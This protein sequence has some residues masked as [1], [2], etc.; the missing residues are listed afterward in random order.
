MPLGHYVDKNTAVHR[1]KPTTKI[2][3]IMVA[4]VVIT[5]MSRTIGI[6]FNAFGLVVL[7]VEVLVTMSV[8][9]LA[10]IP[11][12]VAASQLLP[13]VPVLAFITIFQ[14]WSVGW[15]SALSLAT[16]L[17]VS[18]AL[19]LILTL[20]TRIGDMIESLDLAL[21]PLARFH[22]PVNAISVAIAI[23]IRLIPLQMENIRVVIE[24]RRARSSRGLRAFALPVII[25]SIRRAEAMGEALE[26]RGFDD[27][28]PT[29]SEYVS[30]E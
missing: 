21:R 18:V 23:T 4:V 19:A 11:L 16:S 27:W 28:D 24:A 9:A 14:A 3:L 30:R 8:F 6:H 7:G 26:S 12:S 10:R 29:S 25:H 5:V 17:V 13:V 20:T 22:I 1:L 2:V 15:W